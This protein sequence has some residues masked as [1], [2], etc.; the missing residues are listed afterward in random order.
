MKLVIALVAHQRAGKKTFTNR[1]EEFLKRDGYTVSRHRFSD[2]IRETLMLWNIPHGRE[3]EQ[4][5][6]RMMKETFGEGT[7]SRAVEARFLRDKTDV[8]FLDGVRWLSDE[9]MIRRLAE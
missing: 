2:I 7:L 9:K 5:L 6:S 8:G 1:I 3:N 4:N